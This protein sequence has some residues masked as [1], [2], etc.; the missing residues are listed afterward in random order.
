MVICN[1]TGCNKRACYGLIQKFP[2]NCNEH[3]T[4][5]MIDVIKKKCLNEACNISAT[6]GLIGGKVTYYHFFKV[7][8][9][10]IF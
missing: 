2:L 6:F 5:N 8:I 10:F 4:S 1:F 9:T 3:K 7:L